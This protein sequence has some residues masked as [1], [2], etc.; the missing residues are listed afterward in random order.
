MQK[1]TIKKESLALRCEICH[2]TDLFNAVVGKCQR[3]DSLTTQLTDKKAT[4]QTIRTKS[5][6]YT[7]DEINPIGKIIP[8]LSISDIIF[9]LLVVLVISS[10]QFFP[11]QL[12]SYGKIF[13]FIICFIGVHIVGY[14]TVMS[15]SKYRKLRIVIVL[16]MMVIFIVARFVQRS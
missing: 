11:E 15:Y 10:F 1:L 8:Y 16:F 12:V 7:E 14:H 13:S 2:K 5:T 3:C 6:N 9:C 4:Y